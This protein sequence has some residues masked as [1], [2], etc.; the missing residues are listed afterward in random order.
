MPITGNPRL[1]AIIYLVFCLLGWHVR[2]LDDSLWMGVSSDFQFL[3]APWYLPASS[4]GTVIGMA[5]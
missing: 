5:W 4:G 2:M 3:Y 1:V